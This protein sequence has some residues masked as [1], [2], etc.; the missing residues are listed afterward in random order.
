LIPGLCEKKNSPPDF[1]VVHT[2]GGERKVFPVG[3][4]PAP[5]EKG[6]LMGPGGQRS[7]ITERTSREGKEQK[8]KNTTA[9]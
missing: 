3:E 1:K 8:S 2:E 6:L 4:R 7:W 9:E 5:A